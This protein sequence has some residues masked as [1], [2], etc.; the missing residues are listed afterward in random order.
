[1]PIGRAVSFFL[2]VAFRAQ[3]WPSKLS[4]KAFYVTLHHEINNLRR[5]DNHLAGSFER[6]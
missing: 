5:S 3:N 4:I 6:A 2:E 1:M